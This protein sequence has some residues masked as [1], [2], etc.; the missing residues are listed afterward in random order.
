M[1]LLEGTVSSQNYLDEAHTDC[2]SYRPDILVM[3]NR[4]LRRLTVSINEIRSHSRELA[5]GYV[6]SPSSLQ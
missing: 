2:P 5:D 1:S 3:L 6:T 4:G